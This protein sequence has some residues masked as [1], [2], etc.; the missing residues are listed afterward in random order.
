M[1][2]YRVLYDN[3]TQGRR[4][5]A[6][7]EAI[8]EAVAEGNSPPT[9]RFYAW[10][11]PC[12]SLGYNQ[13][14]RNSVD[15][16]R[17]QANGWEVVRRPTGGRAILHT[18]E[19]TYSIAVPEAHALAKGSVVDSYRRISQGLMAA[20]QRLGMYAKADLHAGGA[21]STAP[22]CFEVPS[23][24]EITTPDGRKL[25][26]SAQVRRKG[27]ILQHGTLPL[28]GD[29]ARIC[30]ALVYEDDSARETAKIQVRDRA[31]TLTDALGVAVSWEA[32]ADAVVAGFNE[33][34]GGEFVRGA[35]SDAEL[36]RADALVESVY[37][38]DAWTF[39]R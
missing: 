21:K 34:F 20:L 23:D 17:V 9:L 37:G 36:G 35:L 12:L 15:M 6:I 39:K 13:R 24:Y 19:L 27:A 7:D 32:A 25:V 22:V 2:Q 29:V 11:P 38:C 28:W 3:P 10:D 1:R 5:M 16:V 33:V 8:M 18:D 14:W 26:G 30:D 31:A 4:N